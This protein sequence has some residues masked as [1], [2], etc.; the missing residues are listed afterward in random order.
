MS[1]IEEFLWPRVFRT[2]GGPAAAAAAEVN[3]EQQQQ[4]SDV[5]GALPFPHFLE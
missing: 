1:A 2:E 3:G 4:R 5:S